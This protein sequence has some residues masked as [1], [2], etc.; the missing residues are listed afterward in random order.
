MAAPAALTL[1]DIRIRLQHLKQHRNECQPQ[2]QQSKFAT[3]VGDKAGTPSDK[4]SSQ[5]SGL[6]SWILTGKCP[7]TWA[8][9]DLQILRDQIEADLKTCS[10]PFVDPPADAPAVVAAAAIVPTAADVDSD[11]SDAA[12]ADLIAK[13][14]AAQITQTSCVYLF[15]DLNYISFPLTWQRFI[16]GIFYIGRGEE[17]RP[18]VHVKESKDA[19]VMKGC[20]TFIRGL[21]GKPDRYTWRYIFRELSDAQMKTAEFK[22]I[23]YLRDVEKKH[24]YLDK[25]QCSIQHQKRAKSSCMANRRGGTDDE[26]Q[27][28]ETDFF[29]VKTGKELLEEAHRVFCQISA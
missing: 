22:M 15:F 2:W 25:H 8:S 3:V 24:F 5:Q 29:R 13:F 28:G 21:Q 7:G 20:P 6:S 16:D 23:A 17:S 19:T 14:H 12:V 11:A 4:R 27:L 26:K 9:I 10:V 1:P 18:S